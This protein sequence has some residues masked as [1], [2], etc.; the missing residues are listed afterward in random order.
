MGLA[1]ERSDANRIV[2]GF[3]EHMQREG[4]KVTRAMFERHLS[5]EIGS[6]Q[7]NADM[8]AVQRPGFEWRPA[9]AAQTVSERLITLLPGE[10]WRGSARG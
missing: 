10:P 8:S 1:D 3:I 7:F 9:E 2:A 5:G 4:I 6:A